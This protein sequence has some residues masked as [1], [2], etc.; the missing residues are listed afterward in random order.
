[1]AGEA[2]TDPTIH[3]REEQRKEEGFFLDRKSEEF[4]RSK[5]E[6]WKGNG[7]L[8]F[9]LLRKRKEQRRRDG[10]KE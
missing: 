2:L 7:F 1:M 6:E 4:Q 10:L 5:L 3:K 9:G 8:T